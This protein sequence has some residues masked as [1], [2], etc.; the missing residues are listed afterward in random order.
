MAAHGIHQEDPG[1]HLKSWILQ[2]RLEPVRSVTLDDLRLQPLG[3]ASAQDLPETVFGS[4]TCAA[5]GMSCNCGAFTM[6]LY[7]IQAGLHVS[8][9]SEWQ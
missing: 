8:D 5:S 1:S 9:D 3:A 6:K 4:A 2:F 7:G